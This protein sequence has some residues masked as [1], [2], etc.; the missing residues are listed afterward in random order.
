MITA[1]RSRPMSGAAKVLAG[2]PVRQFGQERCGAGSLSAV[3]TYHGAPVS[4]EALDAELPK[5]PDGGVLSVDLLLAARRH[6][7]DAR[8]VEGTEGLLREAILADK[9]V[10]LMMRVLDAPGVRRDYYHYV[11]VD[12]V[13]VREGWYRFQFG[14]AEPRWSPLGRRLRGAWRDAGY[15]MLLVEARA[16]AS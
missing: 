8:W 10:I 6:G 7:H 12:G 9:P 14:D 4:V 16:P 13:D 15:A 2:V 1:P 11:I 3:L 5:T